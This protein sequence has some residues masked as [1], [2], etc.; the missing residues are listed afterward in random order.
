[1]KPD[2]LLKRKQQPE[3]KAMFVLKV[4][5]RANQENVLIKQKFATV[6]MVKPNISCLNLKK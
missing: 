2:V 5:L 1:M 6:S 3:L 4:N